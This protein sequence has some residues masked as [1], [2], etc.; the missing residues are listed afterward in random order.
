MTPRGIVVALI[1]VALGAVGAWMLT[2]TLQSM[3]N[4]VQPVDP[5][6]FAMTVGAVLAVVLLA[7][8]IPARTASRVDPMVALRGD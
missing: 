6:I 8:Y 5:P 2:G 7:C 3:L 4:D 1:G